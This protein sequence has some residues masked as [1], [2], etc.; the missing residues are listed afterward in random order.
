[1]G[2]K[3]CA[4]QES[5]V[6]SVCSS[7][8]LLSLS[9]E[10]STCSLHIARVTR[11]M[12]GGWMCLL[13][14]ISHFDSVKTIVKVEVGVPAKVGWNTRVEEGVLYLTEGEEKEIICSAVE[15]YPQTNFAWTSYKEEERTRSSTR[16]ARMFEQIEEDDITVNKTGDILYS[17]VPGSH[18]YSMSQSLLYTAHLADNGTTVQCR[19][20]QSSV[21]GTVLYTSTI[22]LQLNIKELI[23]SK[24]T[25]IEE[26]IGIIS[27]IILAIIFI[28]LMFII[29]TIILTRRRK[30]KTK[31]SSLENKSKD[32]LLTP[33]WVPGKGSR[34]HVSSVREFVHDFHESEELHGLGDMSELSQDGTHDIQDPLCKHYKDISNSKGNTFDISIESQS[35]DS[36]ENNPRNQSV[37]GTTSSRPTTRTTKTISDVSDSSISSLADKSAMQE[38]QIESYIRFHSDLADHVREASE[39]V[40]SNDAT[41]NSDNRFSGQENFH[42]EKVY[43]P[44]DTLT[45]DRISDLGDVSVSC[46]ESESVSRLHETHFGDSISDIPRTVLHSPLVQDNLAD[47]PR[48]IRLSPHI[49]DHLPSSNLSRTG[50]TIFDCELGCFITVEE[51]ERKWRERN[52]F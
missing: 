30:D 16:N 32:E 24:S 52:S 20:Y 46:E 22:E 37:E 33:I 25:A 2:D 11:S 1:M 51:Y 6:N 50:N 3:Q 34:V 29:I 9:G 41:F 14:E 23:V 49:Q 13:N 8:A 19:A 31:Y 4:I 47:I 35:G 44:N 42:S 10:R 21:D 12:H 28:I 17:I 18:L 5:E 38:Y 26:K 36:Y 45:S 40:N 15:G 27:G 39:F 48:N 7:D 43:S